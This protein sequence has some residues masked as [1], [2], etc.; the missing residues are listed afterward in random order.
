M[1]KPIRN[2]FFGLMGISIALG[3]SAENFYVSGNTE[4]SAGE[5][6]TFTASDLMARESLGLVLN[7]P[8]GTRIR[9]SG[10]TDDWGRYSGEIYGAHLKKAGDYRLTVTRD[11]NPSDLEVHTFKVLPGKVSPYKSEIE[12]VD[13]TAPADGETETNFRVR[14]SDNFGNPIRGKSVQVF[15]SRNT[16]IVNHD[17][18]TDA[19]GLILGRTIS[20][21]PG[22]SVLTA[23]VDGKVLFEKPEVVFYLAENTHSMPSVGADDGG[24]G[25]FLKAQLFDDTESDAIARFELEKPPGVLKAGETYSFTVR[26]VDIDGNV[27][28]NYFGNIRFTSTDSKAVLPTDYK[29][30]EQDQGI[31]QFSL[32]FTFNTPG[33]HSITVVDLADFRITGEIEFQ[34]EG[35]GDPNEG[36]DGPSIEILTPTPGTYRSARVSITGKA[37][38]VET[39]RLVDGPTL[40]IDDLPVDESGNFVYQTPALAN[41]VH[42]FQAYDSA[43]TVNSEE[44]VIT[45]DRL[46]PRVMAVEL[47]PPP[48]YD[49]NQDFQLSIKASEPLSRATCVL[50]EVRYDLEA[51]GDKFVTTMQAPAQCGEYIIGCKVADILG[52]ELD[53]PNAAKITVCKPETGI[54]IDGGTGGADGD[55]DGDLLPVDDKPTGPVRPTAVINLHVKAITETRVTLQWDPSIDDKGIDHYRVEYGTNAVSLGS[56]DETPDNRTR[57]YVDNLEPGTHYY[58]RVIA[59]DT[60]GLTSVPSNL[61]DART[62]DP[63]IRPSADKLD[64]TGTPTNIWP[65]ILAVFG[66]MLLLFGF[67]RK[68]V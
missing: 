13:A 50:E 3:V 23:V 57:W 20:Q 24:L 58:F 56:F 62:H 22:I 44:V 9:L 39:V 10:T 43:Q 68:E 34:V 49:P 63:I 4:V 40:L 64:P 66:G 25:K 28:P 53:E 8:D 60:E 55:G 6:A 35:E 31:H 51:S 14:L 46:P 36:G 15:S 2:L 7:R 16:D 59:V 19:N 27:V 33:R 37:V 21:A 54:E 42:K 61:V 48:P 18:T 12:L 38:G 29:Y 26:A 52:N 11:L 41:G 67:R 1:L 32:A 5:I 45:I 17:L 47:S 30:D 65:I